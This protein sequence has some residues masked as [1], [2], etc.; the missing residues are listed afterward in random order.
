M[1]G[2]PMFL[3]QPIVV[4]VR[5]SGA[6]PAGTTATD[7]VLTLT[8][9]LR[10]HGGVGKF[11]EFFGPGCST[12]ETADRTTLSN[13]CPEYGATAAYWP[14]DVETL[15]YPTFTARRAGVVLVE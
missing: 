10:A 9:M 7:L 4:G 12:L 13:M 11:M 3:P 1:L 14:V 15:R 8:Q 5:V 2:Q 6:L